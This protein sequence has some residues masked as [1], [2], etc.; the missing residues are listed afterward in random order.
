MTVVNDIQV[1]TPWRSSLI[2]RAELKRFLLQS[3]TINPSSLSVVTLGWPLLGRSLMFPVC[4]Y[5]ATRQMTSSVVIPKQ[6]ATAEKEKTALSLQ[7]PLS[8]TPSHQSVFVLPCLTCLVS[9][10]KLVTKTSRFESTSL[11]V[12]ELLCLNTTRGRG[13]AEWTR[14]R[15]VL[16]LQVSGQ[17]NSKY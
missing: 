11:Q 16:P 9:N 4:L 2:C 7:L 17:A 3:C 15:Y 13:T 10:S 8:A 6:S 14:E 12:P 5:L 1:I